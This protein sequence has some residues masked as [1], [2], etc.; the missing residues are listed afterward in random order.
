MKIRKRKLIPTKIK[1]EPEP[2]KEVPKVP[3]VKVHSTYKKVG[4]WSWKRLFLFVFIGLCFA[5]IGAAIH[6]ML[7]LVEILPETTRLEEFR[8]KLGTNIYASDGSIAGEFFRSKR[9]L[10]S[11]DEYP[12]ILLRTLLAVEDTTFYRHPG[13]DPFRWPG[14]MWRDIKTQSKRYGASTITQQ[15]AKILYLSPARKW[16]RKIQE[17]ILAL[18][19][20]KKYSKN[21]IL[22]M[23][24]NQVFLGHG[25]HGFKAAAEFYFNKVPKDLDLAEC[26]TLV[27]MLKSPNNYS[28]YKKPV[29]SKLRRGVILTRMY[30][31]GFISEKEMKSA[32][33]EEL[34][35]NPKRQKVPQL[36]LAPYFNDQ[37]RRVLLDGFKVS[38]PTKHILNKTELYEEGYHVETTMNIDLQK[39]GVNALRKGIESVE[40]ERHHHYYYW[41]EPSPPEYPTRIVQDGVYQAKIISVTGSHINASLR[42]VTE[43]PSSQP[44]D[45][46]SVEVDLDKIWLDDFGLLKP[47]YFIQLKCVDP[48]S[49]LKPPVFE[50][51]NYPYAQGALVALDPKSGKILALVGGYNFYDNPNQGQFNRAVL[52]RR[53]PGSGFKPI[54]YAAALDEGFTPTTILKDEPRTFYHGDKIWR[55]KNYEELYYGDVSLRRAL[56]KSLNGASIDL[57]GEIGIPS[58]VKFARA[59]GI[60]SP[61]NRDLTMCLGTSES[62]PLEMAEAYVTFANKG[63]RSTPYLIEKISNRK[64]NLLYEHTPDKTAVIDPVVAYQITSLMEG[65]IRNDGT[66]WRANVIKFPVCGKTGTTDYSMESW[67]CG[68]SPELVC[69]VYVGFDVKKSLGHN[70]TGSH[71]ALPIWIEFM[72]EAFKILHPESKNPQDLVPPLK[73]EIPPEIIRT[74]VCKSSFQLATPDCPHSYEEYY[75]AGTEPTEVCE[76]H[77]S[78][79]QEVD[80][81]RKVNLSLYVKKF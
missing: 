51:E 61:I 80:P 31:V 57:L 58:V 5:G 59:V 78:K 27:G 65:V 29:R 35:L 26:A 68:Y 75:K 3:E 47:D 55:P 19:I 34:Q 63:I 52:A 2:I 70:M 12:P 50:Y 14:A 1:E 17:V 53:Q 76:I 9:E 64:G 32:L 21:E 18:Q 28:P 60:K 44:S 49:D 40:E 73:F 11:I 36:N 74:Q 33:E 25:I 30:E 67:F 81:E 71:A 22:E 46:V 23:Y 16:K 13:V 37:V 41:G 7:Q 15:L 79:N 54:V 77:S 10:A 6:F 62:T 42:T 72:E 43:F 66:G 45:L 38:Y 4:L 48:G 39:A 69:I 20:E 24:M 56:E 8:P